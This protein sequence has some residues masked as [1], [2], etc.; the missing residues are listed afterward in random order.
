MKIFTSLITLVHGQHQQCYE[1]G[2]KTVNQMYPWSHPS[3]LRYIYLIY[4][5]KF[6]ELKE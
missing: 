3:I 5:P 1:V 2:T 6:P 4:G